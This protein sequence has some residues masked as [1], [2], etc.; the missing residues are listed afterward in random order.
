MVVTLILSVKPNPVGRDPANAHRPGANGLTEKKQR[1]P[2]GREPSVS[3]EFFSWFL[4]RG[5]MDRKINQP[6]NVVFY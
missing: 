1:A 2:K 3:K 5:N 4:A 6:I